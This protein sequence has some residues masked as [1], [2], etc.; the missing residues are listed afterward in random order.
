MVS[1]VLAIVGWVA[2]I[3]LGI[4]FVHLNGKVV[5]KWDKSRRYAKH[6]EDELWYSEQRHTTMPD[7]DEYIV[8]LRLQYDYDGSL[9]N[10]LEGK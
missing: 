4:L 8:G 5:D 9:Y 2:V 6:L 1:I 10:T 3:A 7:Y